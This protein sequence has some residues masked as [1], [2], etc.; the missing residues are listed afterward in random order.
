M[1]RVSLGCDCDKRIG[2]GCPVCNPRPAVREP[3]FIQILTHNVGKYAN[4]LIALDEAG[5]V[6]QYQ[7]VA[8]W[9][10]LNMKRLAE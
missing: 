4:K 9:A 2:E 6:W 7:E 5:G 3:E 10:K 1:S 8:G